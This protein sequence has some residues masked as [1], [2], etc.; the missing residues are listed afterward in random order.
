VTTILI[1]NG[2]IHRTRVSE[3]VDKPVFISGRDSMTIRRPSKGVN[4]CNG[5]TLL[6][7]S[8]HCPAYSTSPG[9]P[10][11][12]PQGLSPILLLNVFYRVK[13]DVLCVYPCEDIKV[14]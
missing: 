7:D 13:S 14:G 1:E 11:F 4:A 5:T 6:V 8:L 10:L 9:S 3:Q 12:I 2:L